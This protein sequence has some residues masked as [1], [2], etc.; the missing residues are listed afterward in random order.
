MIREFECL[1]LRHPIIS[2]FDGRIIKD[3]LDLSF[4][5]VH[6]L[7]TLFNGQAGEGSCFDGV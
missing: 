4:S 6:L 5:R 3:S 2:V 7:S 1:G